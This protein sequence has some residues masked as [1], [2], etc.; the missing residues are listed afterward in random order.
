MKTNHLTLC[1]EIIAA[2]S[3]KH[4]KYTNVLWGT[5]TKPLCQTLVCMK[6]P[7]GLKAL[8]KAF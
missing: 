2:R 8:E 7:M 6:Q 5:N 4:A 3:D 1:G